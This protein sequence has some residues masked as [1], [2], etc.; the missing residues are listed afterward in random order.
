V[1]GEI[2]IANDGSDLQST[3][4]YEFNLIEWQAINIEHACRIST[5]SFIRS[6]Q[7]CASTHEPQVRALLRGLRLCA[8]ATAVADRLAG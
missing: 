4:G 5:F 2:I 3:I 8:A 7:R 6:I 1:I